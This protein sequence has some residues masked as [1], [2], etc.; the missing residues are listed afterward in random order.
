MHVKIEELLQSY[1]QAMSTFSVKVGIAQSAEW[2][3]LVTLNIL[4]AI[5]QNGVLRGTKPFLVLYFNSILIPDGHLLCTICHLLNLHKKEVGL[6][7]MTN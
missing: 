6:K 5:S 3:T 1:N 4:D 7:I 2:R